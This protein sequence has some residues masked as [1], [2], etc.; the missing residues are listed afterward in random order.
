MLCDCIDISP[1]Y[2]YYHF[3]LILLKLIK[4]MISLVDFTSNIE[5][6]KFYIYK[7]YINLLVIYIVTIDLRDDQNM[8]EVIGS[9]VEF[10][11]R[12]NADI[13]TVS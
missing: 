3:A 7:L 8:C 10:M 12:Y 9:L 11:F 1:A 6:S 2:L 5:I 13:Y 4:M